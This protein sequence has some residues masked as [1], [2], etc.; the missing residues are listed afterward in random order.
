MYSHTLQDHR[1]VGPKSKNLI[2]FTWGSFR[3]LFPIRGDPGDSGDLSDAS[4]TMLFELL[5]P[6]GLFKWPH[7]S[8]YQTLKSTR[9]SSI[10]SMWSDPSKC[11]RSRATIDANDFNFESSTSNFQL[12]IS[13]FEPPTSSNEFRWKDNRAACLQECNPDPSPVENLF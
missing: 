13:R 2:D 3:R 12:R 11:M 4:L 7:G 9:I 1:H 6:F 8:E 5:A 10:V